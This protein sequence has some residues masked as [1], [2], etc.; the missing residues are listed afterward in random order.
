MTTVE[1]RTNQVM[2][3]L[4]ALL[5][6]LVAWNAGS[7]YVHFSDMQARLQ[8]RFANSTST[9]RRQPPSGPA[10]AET[11]LILNGAA[12]LALLGAVV[13]IGIR[14]RYHM[15]AKRWE[16]QLAQGRAVQN[17]LMPSADVAIPNIHVAAEF[18]PAL[19]VGGDLYDVFTTADGRVAFSLGDVSGKG[20]P[21]ALLMGMIQGAVRSNAWYR[22]QT[23][24]E[25]FAKQLNTMLCNSSASAK[26]ASLFW[27][28][29]D[30]ARARLTYVSAGHCP[31]FVVRQSKIVKLDSTGPVLG[32]LP[33]SRFEQGSIDFKHGDLLVL[34]SDGIV[35]AANADGEEFGEDRLEAALARCTG[36]SA[37]EARQEILKDYRAFLGG[38]APEDDLTLLVLEARGARA[39]L[40]VAA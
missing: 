4:G 15:R 35:E 1:T 19:E 39:S 27:G 23:T 17:Q 7:Q 6:L 21:A 10:P 37:E 33:Q 32:L 34:Y 9:N 3:M 26:F 40:E 11:N 14:T 22:D 30:P 12:A 28:A 36:S 25:A 20:L 8:A 2:L 38:T 16:Q 13:S 29:Y 18:L 31:G 5:A 24:H